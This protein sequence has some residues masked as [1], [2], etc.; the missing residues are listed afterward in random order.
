[1]HWAIGVVTLLALCFQLLPA[2][3]APMVGIAYAASAQHGKPAPP[4]KSH[5][6][7]R[8]SGMAL[9]GTNC[10]SSSTSPLIYD[11]A[12]SGITAGSATIVWES[13]VQ[14]TATVCVNTTSYSGSQCQINNGGAYQQCDV[15]HW[16]SNPGFTLLD[17]DIQKQQLPT[18]TWFYYV[19]V[20]LQ[21][22]GTYHFAISL[23]NGSGTTTFGNDQSFAIPSLQP[24][25]TD[26]F[27]GAAA[28][29][30]PYF[31]E[32]WT[33]AAAVGSGSALFQDAFSSGS[34]L[35]S[36]WQTVSGSWAVDATNG[37][38]TSSAAGEAYETT[39]SLGSTAGAGELVTSITLPAV[40]TQDPF[41]NAGLVVYEDPTSPYK[42]KVVFVLDTTSS[43]QASGTGCSTG[44]LASGLWLFYTDPSSG[45]SKRV[46]LST[47][48]VSAFTPGTQY[49]FDVRV[50]GSF[51]T[52]FDQTAPTSPWTYVASGVASTQVASSATY[53]VSKGQSGLWNNAP[54]LTPVQFGPFN[55]YNTTTAPSSV[56]PNPASTTVQAVFNPNSS[57]TQGTLSA[58]SSIPLGVAVAQDNDEVDF[59]SDSLGGIV[60][61][62]DTTG[63]GDTFSTA[64]STNGIQGSI[65]GTGSQGQASGAAPWQLEARF[66]GA[67]LSLYGLATGS[68]TWQLLA[69]GNSSRTS[70]SYVWPLP[71]A[72]G[73]VGSFSL[74]AITGPSLANW[75][76]SLGAAVAT[77]SG[78]PNTPGT[79]ILK[80]VGPG[81]E[82]HTSDVN[83]G[84]GT[85]V[86]PFEVW[87]PD[88][89]GLKFR[90]KDSSDFY[91]LVFY[92]PL[93]Y[94]SPTLLRVTAGAATPIMGF[95]N[96]CNFFG[97]PGPFTAYISLLGNFICIGLGPGL[98][99]APVDEACTIDPYTW[100]G[101]GVGIT[102][103]GSDIALAGIRYY[104]GRDPKRWFTPGMLGGGVGIGLGTY[105]VQATD[106]AFP[107]T[108][109][110][111]LPGRGVPLSWSRTYSSSAAAQGITGPLGFGWFTSYG[112]PLT[113]NADSSV[114][115]T[116]AAGSQETFAL[117]TANT[118]YTPPTGSMETLVKNPDG[119]YS[120]STRDH[121]VST[122]QIV[123]ASGPYLLTRQVDKDG[124]TTT[125]TYS[126]SNTLSTITDAVGRSFT[127][128]YNS[129]AS[130]PCPAGTLVTQVSDSTRSV[131]YGYDGACDLTAVTDPAGNTTTYAYDG[132]TLGIHHLLTQSCDAN[133]QPGVVASPK[134]AQNT[135]AADP[136]WD[137]AHAKYTPSGGYRLTQQTDPM[138]TITQFTYD[139]SK[140][141]PIAGNYETILDP[142]AP[143]HL[144]EVTAYHIN[145]MGQPTSITDPVG[146]VTQLTYTSSGLLQESVLDPNPPG[147]SG[148]LNLTSQR[149]Y[150]AFGNVTET[151]DPNGKVV[152]YSYGT[153]PTAADYN[154][155]TQM[156]V[157]PV[158]PS[159]GTH[160]N[161]TFT[162]SYYPQSSAPSGFTG[163]AGDVYSVTDPL[164]A[165][166]RFSYTSAGQLARMQD[167]NGHDTIFAYDAYGQFAQQVVDPTSLHPGGL[168]LTS[169]SQYDSLGRL[170]KQT[171]P[172]GIST[173]HTFDADGRELQTVEDP[174]S[175]TSNPQGLNL[176]VTYAYDKVANL[177]RQTVDPTPSGGLTCSA[178][179]GGL[180]RSRCHMNETTSS[181]YDADNRLLTVTSPI[182]GT[183]VI[184]PGASVA[185]TL[186]GV[187]TYAYDAA[188]NQTSVTDPQGNTTTSS[189]DADNR[190]TQVTNPLDGTALTYPDGRSHSIDGTTTYA[191][192]AAGRVILVADPTGLVTQNTYTNANLTSIVV[193]PS[194]AHLQE[195]RTYDTS[196]RLSTDTDARGNVTS[197]AYDA[198]NQLITAQ[199]P[200]GEQETRTYDAVG[201]LLTYVGDPLPQGQTTGHANLTTQ[202]SYDAA[203]RLVSAVRDPNSQGGTGHLAL[204]TTSTYDA[205]S[206]T[207]QVTDPNGH[208]IKYGYDRV[209]HQISV[210][211]AHAVATGGPAWRFTFD[212]AG[213]ERQMIDPLG[214]VTAT[215]YDALNRPIQQVTDPNP[216]GGTGHLQLLRSQ[217]YDSNG[218]VVYTTN[219]NGQ[220]TA[221]SYNALNELTKI[222]YHSATTPDVAYYYDDDGRQLYMTDGTGAA[223]T[224]WLAAY[225]LLG[226]PAGVTDP[227]HQTVAY[228][229]DANGNAGLLTS[230]TYPS[231]HGLS[232]T[233]DLDGRL[234]ALSSP[235]NTL[236]GSGSTAGTTSFQYA[237]DTAGRPAQVS[238]PNGINVTYGYDTAG[239][240]TSKTATYGSNT[241]ASWT[242]TFDNDGNPTAVNDST[243]GGTQKAAYGYDE[244]NRLL[245]ASYWDGTSQTYAYDAA[246]NRSSQISGNTTTTYSY[247]AAGRLTAAGGTT[248][249]YDR[250]GN[251]TSSTTGGAT[252]SYTYDQA[253]RMI[254]VSGGAAGAGTTYTFNGDGVRVA[255]TTTST[256]A[257]THYTWD[258]A[259]GALLSDGTNEYVDSASGG[260]V[261]QTPLAGGGGA[262][263]F[264]VPDASG[265]T[266]V[267][268]NASGQTQ[269]T[270]AYDAFGVPKGSSGSATSS[271]GYAGQLTDSPTGFQ[272]LR[273]R[274]YDPSTGQFTSQDSYAGSGGQPTSLNRYTYTLDAPMTYGDPGGHDISLC[275]SAF[276]A[277][278]GSNG[279]YWNVRLPPSASDY[280]YGQLAH[281]ELFGGSVGPIVNCVQ[282]HGGGI[283]GVSGCVGD[284]TYQVVN[285]AVK[286]GPTAAE[287]HLGLNPDT[288]NRAIGIAVVVG[289][290]GLLLAPAVMAGL[291]VL[292][293]E[294]AAAVILTGGIVG[295]VEGGLYQAINNVVTGKP[296]NDNVQQAGLVGGVLGVGL[297][298]A[299]V[300]LD[301]LGGDIGGDL[302]GWLRKGTAADDADAGAAGA[303]CSFASDT[304]VATP[305]GEKT[306]ASLHIGDTVLAYDPT[307][308]RAEPEL[309]Q[310][311]WINHDSDLVDVGLQ[312]SASSGSTTTPAA[313]SASASRGKQLVAASL[314]LAATLAVRGHAST[315][316][317]RAAHT[318]TSQVGAVTSITET[319]HTTANHPWLTADRGWVEASDLQ[320]GEQVVTLSGATSTVAWV[321]VVPGQA[322]YYNLTVAKDH[323]YAVG[324]GDYVVHNTDDLCEIDFRR[325]DSNNEVLSDGQTT[326]KD[327]RESAD[328]C[329]YCS[330]TLNPNDRSLAPRIGHVYPNGLAKQYVTSQQQWDAYLTDLRGLRVICNSCNGI[331]GGF[332]GPISPKGFR[333]IRGWEPPSREQE[334]Q[335]IFDFIAQTY[336]FG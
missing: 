126:T 12:V 234:A 288:V 65:N 165:T 254:G 199:L 247:D 196:G 57:V 258:P 252:T 279:L 31:T 232:M 3:S 283:N 317:A 129:Q 101:G 319:I 11:C 59:T 314:A 201:N 291:G 156:T 16:G 226:R 39:A 161:A 262:A 193:D 225:D 273:A 208:T 75:Q 207:L 300:A 166:K 310:H 235:N 81:S 271:L 221:F 40:S 19:T 220:T 33:G 242:Y 168:N 269:G 285:D 66:D 260:L 237:Y 281:G 216:L 115:L 160:V 14:V 124:N 136:N 265:S 87:N 46:A 107:S 119:S 327:F 6:Q 323:T 204:T 89:A 86:V 142:G 308:G 121:A 280:T 146:T 68:T 22:A 140:N 47:G 150:D 52:I 335:D 198:N 149:L 181:T 238:Y 108:T 334:A 233:Y 60:V 53:T 266:R 329:F 143:P 51:I 241:V 295:G 248:Y 2:P 18:G 111:K 304:P 211:D 217:Y 148:H 99:G 76:G 230:V 69:I 91:E 177:L 32:N 169:T 102:Q 214:H 174:Y 228:G 178:A 236:F 26:T 97:G 299:G 287:Q 257:T 222:A 56:A 48:S 187:T 144:N 311:V 240:G 25:F 17:G 184:Y 159:G 195:T 315:S 332:K 131:L 229:Y 155:V 15:S 215:Q 277:G 73:V 58:A 104:S 244:A 191:Y 27:G 134:C 5:T 158:P 36:S 35:S 316:A 43:C 154:Q 72:N 70:G 293:I 301:W 92:Q 219:A 45:T 44:E 270:A 64:V 110:N 306:I 251:R 331:Q 61:R 289:V 54:S 172:T 275:Y 183:T 120:L 80:D 112:R 276:C 212:Y 322:D 74:R 63:S 100:T 210:T 290:V 127:F 324:D 176:T 182:N 79:M 209:G 250:D 197:Y 213:N 328:T 313:T 170:L 67:H 185:T 42:G 132:G 90:I 83:I 253:D 227:N 152:A 218:N 138:G 231:G 30:S 194:G 109:G 145:N 77:T 297:G 137:P 245:S 190:Q 278:W 309:V 255:A 37:Y 55:L 9:T 10:A 118:T 205:D 7:S 171:D 267:L 50:S 175:A 326:T 122:W 268:T 38:A 206:R 202:Y 23:Q 133:N 128:T 274:L 24:D 114:S 84:D 21:G 224:Y 261:V 303:K 259:S 151:I 333:P 286:N 305:S 147:G 135:Y 188:G 116:N 125:F 186:N 282:A 103:G 179:Y 320:L 82:V 130:G 34:T 307:T 302:A 78:D 163:N 296:W 157:D 49:T 292:G 256:Q 272:Y 13:D 321:Q 62:S 94:Y 298:A 113:V 123:N 249:G 203:N 263:L 153:D 41:D 96:T 330:K 1:M 246:G 312:S 106:L 294:G 284:T 88:T 192:D 105:S 167:A 98:Y 71:T 189:Y 239:R 162:F 20:P 141:N 85:L 164:N 318:A 325:L 223:G 336:G 28:A 93:Q 95:P 180:Y 243:V 117:D 264:G 29:S 8:F 4:L 139:T 200:L 173:T